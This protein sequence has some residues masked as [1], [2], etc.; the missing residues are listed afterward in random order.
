MLLQIKNIK[1][2]KRWIRKYRIRIFL[3]S[4][5]IKKT[6]TCIGLSAGKLF[7]KDKDAV[8]VMLPSDHHIEYEKFIYK[9]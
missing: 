1:R 7:K 2:N 9:P 4:H 6:A 8:M 3:L 5:K